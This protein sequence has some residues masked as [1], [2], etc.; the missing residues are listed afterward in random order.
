MIWLDE[1]FDTVSPMHVVSV[2]AGTV[3]PPIAVSA[4]P[5][6][7]DSLFLNAFAIFDY[8]NAT[9]RAVASDAAVLADD[10]AAFCEAK[11]AAA[12]VDAAF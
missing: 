6:S 11:A 4:V 1:V 3:Y 5:M 7:L 2:L 10:A 8:P 12:D 9:A